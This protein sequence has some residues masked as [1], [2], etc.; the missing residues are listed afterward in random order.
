LNFLLVYVGNK[1]CIMNHL[2][3]NNQSGFTLIEVIVSTA[4]LVILALGIFSLIL[5]SLRV[6]ADN[7]YYVQAIEIANQKMEQIR[8]LPYDKVG[9]QGGIPGGSIPQTEIINREGIFTVN[10]YI[11]YYDDPYDGL[12]GSDAIVNDYKIATIKVSWAGK[13]G[14]KSVTIFSKIIPRTEE[15]NEGYGLLKISASNADAEPL[16]G[17]NVRVVNSALSV[18]VTNPTNSD[19]ILYLPA[20]ASFQNYKIT[21]TKTDEESSG[22]YYGADRTYDISTGKS[23][24]HL[25]VTEGDKTEEN[26]TIDKLAHLRIRTVSNNLPANW[27]V[28]SPQNARNQIN[29]NFSLDGSDNMYFIWQSDTA[30]SSYI[31]AQKYNSSSVKQWADDYKISNTAFQRNPDI[32]AAANGNSFIVWQDNSI[33]L[34]QI[35]YSGSGNYAKKNAD[36]IINSKTTSSLNLKKSNFKLLVSRIN[37]YEWSGAGLSFAKNAIRQ[38]YKKL[39]KQ[40]KNNTKKIYNNTSALL[41]NLFHNN[42]TINSARAAGLIVQTKIGAIVNNNNTLTA[43]FNSQPTEGN[44]IIAIAVHRNAYKSFNL[45][46]NA[47]GVF[48]KS[49]YSDSSWY[50]DVGIWHKVI[51]ANEP[52][53]VTITS[54]GNIKGGVLMIMEVSGLDINNLIDVVSTNDE[55]GSNGLTASTG[56]TAQS[57]SIGFGVAAAA[58]ADNNFVTPNSSNWTSTSNDIWIQRLWRDW[59]QGYDGSLAVATMDIT[60]ANSQSAALALSGGGAEQRNSALAVFR[61]KT[62][63]DATVSAI[64]SQT[65]SMMIPS[66]GQYAG[67]AFVITDDTGA[68]N[69]TGITISENGTVDAQNNLSNIKLYYDIDAT[70]PYDCAGEQYDAGV[71]AQFGAAAGFNGADGSASFTDNIGISTS[72]TLCVY[73]VLDV[74]SG[75]GKDETIEIKINNPAND[76][77]IDTGAVLPDTAVEIN[78]ST[79]LLKPAELSQIHY[80]WRDDDGSETA[81]SWKENQ[82]TPT[83]VK[84]GSITRL[85]FEISNEG[86]VGSG[87]TQYRIEYGESSTNCS[88]ILSWTALPNDSSQHWQIIN[89]ANLTDGEATTNIS[90]LTDENTN[91]KAGEAKDADNQTSAITLASNEFTELEYTIAATSNASDSNYCFRLTDAGSAADFDYTEYPEISI[92]GDENIYIA[93]L[94]PDSG[95]LWSVKKVN[96]DGTNTDQ[97]NP[98]IAITSNSATTTVIWQDERNGNIDIYAQTL[99]VYGNKLWANDLQITAS[100]TDEYSPAVSFDSNDNIVVAW[101]NNNISDEE[102]YMQ[103]FDLAG[104]KIWPNPKNISNSSFNDYSPSLA[105]DNSNNIY[106]SWTENISGVLNTRLAKLNSDGAV[107]WKTQANI[108]SSGNNQYDSAVA[109]NNSLSFVYVSWTDDRG[110][111]EDIY[112]QKYDFNGNAQWTNDVKININLTASAQS[113]SVLAINSADEPFAAWQ[114]N[115]DDNYNIYASNFTDPG[116]PSGYGNVPIRVYGTKTISETPVIYEFDHDQYTDANGYADLSLEWDAG[117]SIEL[118]SAST[119]LKIIYT[120][121]IQP[122]EIL[123][124]ETK[125]W[126]IYVE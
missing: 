103:K 37:R 32:A 122:L 57:A 114:D 109:I 112:A 42:L 26:F 95:E 1:L 8:N 43:V 53:Q 125:E 79:V 13:F 35:T 47:A 5:L 29:A 119:S 94:N 91:F 111:N 80:R 23:P 51:G 100:S 93:G 73:T 38:T 83:T 64:N 89:S 31:Y 7:K 27:R 16:A 120:D 69:V 30:T 39:I 82:D 4:I 78:G 55:T 17:A 98:K 124:D 74:L 66:A 56:S 113:N 92:I 85:R 97:T 36:N 106:L 44:V 28:N 126:I 88:D 50:L 96:S 67:G 123:P 72:K 68:H 25:S 15:T 118:V 104:I 76:I 21:V 115:R 6:T 71:D 9:V 22:I 40:L 75:A 52:S 77:T 86:S 18:D 14:N 99:D 107:Q 34:K 84:I 3:K 87:A 117:Y 60:A 90:G 62:P 33:H 45:P 12:A 54:D 63:N 48:T 105:V 116:S 24:V 2:I 121:P 70:A 19:G 20:L 41:A 110:G 102:I 108:S 11:T 46:A 101:V 58:F 65:A 49:A 59:W 81:A 10:T 61:I